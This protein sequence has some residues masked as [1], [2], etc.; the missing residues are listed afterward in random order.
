MRPPRSGSC[1]LGDVIIG[2]Y[3]KMRAKFDGGSQKHNTKITLHK[4]NNTIAV[5]ICMYVCIHCGTRQFQCSGWG[6]SLQ[7]QFLVQRMCLGV[8]FTLAFRNA[9]TRKLFVIVFGDSL[10][11]YNFG[12]QFI[13]LLLFLLSFCWGHHFLQGMMLVA[14]SLIPLQRV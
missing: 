11:V 9:C 10:F 6:W 3:I 5:Y 2:L 14:A 12:M 4:K 13:R 7:L 1:A 8:L